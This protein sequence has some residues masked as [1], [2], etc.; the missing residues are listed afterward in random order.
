[1]SKQREFVEEFERHGGIP[2]RVARITCSSCGVSTAINIETS[3]GFLVP[4]AIR[5]KF[6]RM[7]WEVG[8]HSNRDLC[9][10]CVLKQKEKPAL[11][12]VSSS[13]TP[14]APAAALSPS[15][16]PPRT[17]QRDDRRIIFE[18][19]NEVYLDDKRGYDTGWSDQRVAADLGVPRKWVELIR[20]ENFGDVG[21]NADMVEYL[22]Q[23]ES[24]AKG[25]REQL[26]EARQ[27][28]EDIQGILKKYP[29]HSIAEI[30]E[31]LGKV[32]RLAA[33]VRKLVTVS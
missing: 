1:M 32:E 13:P 25:A 11:K 27:I 8:R 20:A 5:M 7:R 23:A 31:R 17:M 15:E 3:K 9:P 19:L 28:Y 33:E 26:L 30:T 4:Q 29:H 18:K 6:E 21:A 2:K 14:A 16:Q 22:H 12:I 10:A 24:L